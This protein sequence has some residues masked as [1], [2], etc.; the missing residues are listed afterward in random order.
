MPRNSVARY[1]LLITLLFSILACTSLF[2]PRPAVA[3]DTSPAAL[4]IRASNCCGLVPQTFVDNYVP[5][6]QLWGDGRLVWVESG[7]G[8]ARQILTATLSTAEMEALLQSFV[9]A[10]FFGWQASYADYSVTDMPSTCLLVTLLSG[11]KQVCEYYQGA[12]AAFHQLFAEV[13]RGAGQTG[14]EFV[15]ERGYLTAYPLPAGQPGLAAEWQWPSE[16][17]GFGLAEAQS[18]LWVDGP[19]LDLAWSVVSANYWN[20]TVQDGADYYE[21]TV[22]VPGVSWVSPP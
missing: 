4:V 20:T 3:W 13:V 12:P 6:A 1:Q 5:D 21:I 10:G 15:P 8:G 14:T 2:P 19:A 17:V 16:A 7:A 11:A 9:D 22:K 18:G